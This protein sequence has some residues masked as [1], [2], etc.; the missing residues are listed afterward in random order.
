M[1]KAFL[2]RLINLSASILRLL[3]NKGTFGL[4]LGVSILSFIEIFELVLK[5]VHSHLYNWPSNK[6]KHEQRN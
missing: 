4:F 6:V 2:A 3:L 5:I 1:S